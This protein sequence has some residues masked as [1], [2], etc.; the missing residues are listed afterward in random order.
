MRH[1]SAMKHN[2]SKAVMRRV[3]PDRGED[4][5]WY[6]RLAMAAGTAEGQ[7]T[8]CDGFKRR[9]LVV[10]KSADEC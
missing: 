1:V 2:M 6:S 10:V 5:L 4:G 7:M 3:W 9:G 8:N